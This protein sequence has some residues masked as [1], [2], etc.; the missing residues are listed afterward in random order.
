MG[1]EYKQIL[2]FNT[3]ELV[4]EQFG[5]LPLSIIRPKRSDNTNWKDKGAFLE[6]IEEELRRSNDADYL[7]GLGFSE[8]H[9]GLAEFIV[10][11]WSLPGSV[12]VDP[13]AGRATRAVVSSTLNRRYFG[14]EIS[15]RTYNRV[16]EHLQKQN[17]TA[18]IYLSDGILMQHTS[19]SS[20]D[21]IMT[22]PPYWNIEKYEDVENQLS[23]EPSYDSFMNRISTLSTNMMGVLKPGAFCCWVCADFR[24]GGK[25]LS[26]HSDTIDVFQKAG[27]LLHDTV[28]IHND[29][30]FAALQAGKVASKR[31]TSKIHEYLLVFRKPGNYIVPDYCYIEKSVKPTSKFFSFQ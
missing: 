29:S 6:P 1:K 26:F 13:F 8:F 31:Y 15:P 19:L 27:L 22:C 7:P 11:Y 20:A 16:I 5:E 10:R 21:L 17:S 23:S 3:D 24:V 30:P 25:L 18:K 4:S 14:Y 12:I 9:A 28:I 2:P